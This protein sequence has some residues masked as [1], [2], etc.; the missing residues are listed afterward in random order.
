VLCVASLRR[1]LTGFAVG[2]VS[3]TA[4]VLCALYLWIGGA[5]NDFVRQTIVFPLFYR[6]YGLSS[7][8]PFSLQWFAYLIISEPASIC[9]TLL[10]LLGTAF[11]DRRLWFRI[12]LPLSFCSAVIYS[13]AGGRLY[14]NYF[15]MLGP[16]MLVSMSLIPFYVGRRDRAG[17]LLRATLLALGIYCGL[18]PL[19]LYLETGSPF[20]TDTESTV[21]ATAAYVEQ[22]SSEQDRVL[23][24]GFAPQIYVLSGR[25]NTFKDATLLSITGGNFASTATADQGRLPEMVTQF[26]EYLMR[27]PPDLIVH[28]TLT[29]APTGSCAGKGVVQRNLDF[30]QV[31]HLKPLRDLIATSYRQQF[32]AAGECDRAVVYVRTERVPVTRNETRVP[33]RLGDD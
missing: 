10:G 24:W 33:L 23:V 25:Y 16:P 14:P 31:A 2:A 3:L 5:W 6:N 19:W 32:A 22:H 27:T 17:T 30:H 13:A 7:D 4:P 18:K 21:E 15:V 11:V 8:I 1:P 28:Y 12:A 26:E 29:R 20:V 9:L